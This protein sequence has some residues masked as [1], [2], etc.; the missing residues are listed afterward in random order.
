MRLSPARAT[1]CSI[2]R[3][4]ELFYEQPVSLLLLIS[5]AQ[6]FV[7]DIGGLSFFVDEGSSE[8]L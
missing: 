8:R 1:E 5:V 4:G 7:D 3:E 6:R 2:A